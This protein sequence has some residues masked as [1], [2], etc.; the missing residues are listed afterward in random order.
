MLHYVYSSFIYN[1]QNLG[2]NSDVP[3]QRNGHRKYGTF[4]QWNIT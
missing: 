4:T 3:Q 1:S 2:K